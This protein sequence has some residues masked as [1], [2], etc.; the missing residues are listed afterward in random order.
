LIQVSFEELIAKYIRYLRGTFMFRPSLIIIYATVM[1]SCALP[2]K[3]ANAATANFDFA[4]LA[5]D[6]VTGVGEGFWNS[7]F[8]AAGHNY[9]VNGIGVAA[10]ATGNTNSFSGAY[11]DGPA[12]MP[13]SAGLGVC[14]T[15]GGCAG[16]NDDNVGR[17]GDAAGALPETLTLT[18]TTPVKLTDLLFRDANH[19]AFIGG[20]LL[21]N[22]TLFTTVAGPAGSNYGELTSVLLASL[23]A[24][25]TFNF[26]SLSGDSDRL[27]RDFYLSGATV[28]TVPVP[29]A[30]PLFVTGL[31]LLGLL[32][33]R[34]KRS[35]AA[36]A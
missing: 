11:L 16:T 6:P 13:R 17:I 21:I 35:P 29:P 30:L 12:G 14:S 1:L 2:F 18:F 36:A 27:L 9:F 3:H 26:T 31:G 33:R 25:T 10:S 5:V 28:S 19:N 7:K 32:S 4:T 20:S 23:L 22:G 24:G 34:R 8:P 15:S